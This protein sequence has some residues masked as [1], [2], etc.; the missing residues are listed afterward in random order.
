[1]QT[2]D[3]GPLFVHVIQLADK[4]P[5]FHRATSYELNEP[6]RIARPLVVRVWPRKGL[7]FGWWRR[8]TLNEVEA[9]E[10]AIGARGRGW[11]DEVAQDFR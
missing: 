5:L 1:M 10:K 8:S 7:V 9:L 6:Y 4:A 3:I 11:D 2:H